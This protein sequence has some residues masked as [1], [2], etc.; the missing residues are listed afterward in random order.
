[1]LD[2]CIMQIRFGFTPR[3]SSKWYQTSH[4]GKKDCM[5]C[6]VQSVIFMLFAIEL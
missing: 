3:N 2:I 6:E 5:R 1:M 4:F